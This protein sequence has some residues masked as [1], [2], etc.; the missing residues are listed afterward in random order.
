MTA[1]RF[2]PDVERTRLGCGVTLTTFALILIGGT[3]WLAAGAS[4]IT[5]AGYVMFGLLG[6]LL[7]LGL[8]FA[9]R[10]K[11]VLEID[12]DART[13]RLTVDGRLEGSGP[14]DNLGPLDVRQK[15]RVVST[16]RGQETRTSYAVTAS[17]HRQLD[18]Y[19]MKTPG[20]ARRK[21]EVLA[22]RW[23]LSAQSFGGDIRAFEDL[24]V[25]LHQRL[26]DDAGARAVTTLRPEWCVRVE[27]IARGYAFHS[28]HRSWKPLA[29]SALIMGF[30]AL[31]VLGAPGREA[32][33]MAG[34][35]LGRVLL[36][37]LG[38]VGLVA[39]G[40][41]WSGVRDT[42]F[43][44]TVTVTADG[45]S[46]RG[47]RIRLADI[48]EVMTSC[49]I[50]LVGDRRVF[51]LGETFCPRRATEDVAHELQRVIIEVAEAYPH[52]R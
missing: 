42:F 35:E 10:R 14:L 41:L 37:L 44:G 51:T 3:G 2:L 46:Y 21:M 39:L 6:G 7:A 11:D 13:Y 5:G 34:D 8:W 15:T 52:A 48:E 38:V 29:T 31:F 22:R 40:G 28:T 1:Q 19:S 49:P 30:L 36:G 45:V 20:Q 4:R 27:P 47:R 17:G 16:K 32:R 33:E 23:R 12:L 24:D 50:E 9:L 43:P 25:P 26:R 18:L